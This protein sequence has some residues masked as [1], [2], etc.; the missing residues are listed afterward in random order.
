MSV[1]KAKTTDLMRTSAD[2]HHDKTE[3]KPLQKVR[4]TVSLKALAEHNRSRRV[5][6][7]NAA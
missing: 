1:L 7:G 6:L 4:R 3:L 5:Q 2:F